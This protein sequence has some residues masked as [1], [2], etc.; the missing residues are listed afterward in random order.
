MKINPYRKNNLFRFILAS[1]FASVLLTPLG[2]RIFM[3]F[4]W[5]NSRAG[6]SA[7]LYAALSVW[8]NPYDLVTTFNTTAV[9][10][11]RLAGFYN[12]LPLRSR[13]KAS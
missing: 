8:G 6:K 12:D 5:G 9:G 7:A 4:N 11:E 1:S 10:I 3:V 2:H 13:R